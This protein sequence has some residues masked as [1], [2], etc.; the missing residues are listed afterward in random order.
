M[1]I[2]IL[3]SADFSYESGSIIYAKRL[4]GHLIGCG[5]DCHILSSRL[6]VDWNREWRDRLTVQ[7]DLLEH[8]IIDD[9]VIETADY[10]RSLSI[11][12][13]FL[14]DVHQFS[15]LDVVH[16]HYGSFNSLAAHIFRG[17]SGVPFVVSSFGRDLTLGVKDE[18]IRWMIKNSLNAAGRI[19]I[20]TDSLRPI[21]GQLFDA[22]I[23]AK[24]TTI[25]M[26]VD[27]TIF[28]PH[29]ATFRRGK[30]IVASI[31]SC[32]S[33]EK[34]I[35]T[36]LRAFSLLENR[37]SVDLVIAGTD[38]HPEKIHL[39]RLHNLVQE[40]GL[41]ASVRFPGY[42]RR[43]EVGKLLGE[44]EFLVDARTHGNFSSVLLEAQFT[45]CISVAANTP[46]ARQVIRD[47]WNGYLFPVGDAQA[48]AM[49]IARLLASGADEREKV[50]S[51]MMD[52]KERFGSEYQEQTCFNKLVDV[53]QEAI[54]NN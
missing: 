34:G 5:H 54:K 10:V 47:G 6:P 35:E 26:P 48:L 13:R 14:S 1:R 36:I 28:Q 3:P 38:D 41:N 43:R 42:L 52:W 25:P 20:S 40:L 45:K 32:F 23:L 46:P 2:A 15:A 18:R 51:N 4:F 21:L 24:V 27:Q 33:P 16:A 50:R 44:A 8:P 22:S 39:K 9:R 19:V 12:L 31:N 30:P 7:E 49:L 37:E 53:Y 17:L 11:A 29:E